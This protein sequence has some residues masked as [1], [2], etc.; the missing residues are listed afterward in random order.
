LDLDHQSLDLVL[1]SPDL[2]H[3]ITGRVGGD[4]STNDSPR[5]T[6]GSSESSLAGHV[7]VWDVLVFAQERK[8]EENSEGSGVGSEDDD[9]GNSTVESLGC[10]EEC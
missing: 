3:Q 8:M 1:Q 2:V 4:A 9:L 5:H 10:W 6:T 7:N